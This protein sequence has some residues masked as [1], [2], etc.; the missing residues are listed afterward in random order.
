MVSDQRH[1]IAIACF[2]Q[3]DS[4]YFS[5]KD[6]SSIAIVEAKSGRIDE[7][8]ERMIVLAVNYMF[9]AEL[10]LKAYYY[11]FTNDSD[12][13]IKRYKHHVKRLYDD[14]PDDIKEK[15][16]QASNFKSIKEMEKVIEIN[17]SAFQEIRYCFEKDEFSFSIN[18]APNI[19]TACA[20]VIK[21][22]ILKS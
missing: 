11:G 19:A 12:E 2:R 13:K 15:I 16:F 21:P 14:L 7:S 10:Y 9:A 22:I 17:D 4:F 3:A 1:E 18:D 20:K 8:F 5:A 6:L